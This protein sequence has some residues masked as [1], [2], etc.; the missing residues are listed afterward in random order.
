[1]IASL[2]IMLD[3]HLNEQNIVTK[4]DVYIA[5]LLDIPCSPIQHFVEDLF[6]IKRIRVSRGS[7]LVEICLYIALSRWPFT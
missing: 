1:M 2:V 5:L 6:T 3:K 7:C 4:P